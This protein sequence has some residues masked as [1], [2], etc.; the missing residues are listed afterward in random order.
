MTAT[1]DIIQAPRKVDVTLSVLVLQEDYLFVA[2]CPAL[3]MS[4]YGET[5][6]EARTH[7]N[8]VLRLYLE[9][10]NRNGTLRQDLLE[11]GWVLNG[12]DGIALPE[13]IDIDIPAGLL[14]KQFNQKWNIV[15]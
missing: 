6:A 11:H 14:K 5:I 3:D 15:I 4:A 10:C 7:F 2:Y 9:E 1:T 12:D 13:Q 8:E